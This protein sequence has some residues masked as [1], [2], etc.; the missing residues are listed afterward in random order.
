MVHEPAG[1]A[2]RLQRMVTEES[3]YGY[4]LLRHLGAGIH[5]HVDVDHFTLTYNPLHK[6]HK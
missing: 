4:S 5:G 3:A 2:I 6:K 1:K